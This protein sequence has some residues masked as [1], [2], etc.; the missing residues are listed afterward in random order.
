[1]TLTKA[2]PISGLQHPKNPLNPP[3]LGHFSP[4][5][6][7]SDLDSETEM[8]ILPDPVGARMLVALPTMAERSAGGIIIPSVVNERER[9]AAVVGKVLQQG[10]L[11]YKDIRRFGWQD[12]ETGKWVLGKPWCKEGDTVL[13][14]RYA[15]QRF[16]S[17]DLESGE[18]VEYRMLTD[19]EI[20]GTVP[21][22]AH[23][24]G[25]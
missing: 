13:F 9:A 22:G 2:A 12:P 1:M 18:M 23:V 4:Q 17:K 15:G 10:E 3:T 24:G 20:T 5:K 11:C 25:L 7:P 14:S 6:P 16:K 19:D 21:D 8:V